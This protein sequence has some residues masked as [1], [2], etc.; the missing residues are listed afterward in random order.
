MKK[1]FFL[2]LVAGM[3]VIWSSCEHKPVVPEE[4]EPTDLTQ[5]DLKVLEQGN[6][7][8]FKLF[9]LMS[10]EAPD[11][12][13]CVSPYS[14]YTALAMAANGAGS[15]TLDEML[16]VLDFEG[17]DIPDLNESV[18]SINKILLA[19]D[20]QTVFET[21]NSVWYNTD[22]FSVYPD[23]VT[24]MNTYY[25]AS[26]EGLSFSDPATLPA[27]NGWVKEKTHE[28][29]DKI[30][31]VISP[32]DVCYLINALYFNGQ[33]TT[34]FDKEET[35][36]AL[37][38]NSDGEYNSVPTMYL[39]DTVWSIVNEDLQAVRLPYGDESWGMY[40][41]LPSLNTDLDVWC[42]E[43]LK[44]GWG[45]LQSQ[46]EPV[47]GMEVYLPQFKMESSFELSKQ[48]KQ[49]GMPTAFSGSADFSGLGPGPLAISQ[50]LHKT[51][52][53]VNEEGTEAAAVTAVVITRTSVPMNEIRF[54]RP[55]VF[56]IAEK[57]TGSIIFIGKLN[58][59][60]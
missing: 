52:I 53:D 37:F 60:Q 30:I 39:K 40:L 58:N 56:V 54:N 51:F 17:K 45:E 29:I 5:N 16:A 1:L 9:E 47:A 34:S 26:V 41:F 14:V 57:T 23:F 25:S 2:M 33:W 48:L 22:G 8:G 21:A 46:F 19:K 11:S 50:V 43:A 32:D 55:F 38:R 18:R 20:P 28:K 31:E 15:Q 42:S 24:S 27:I 44:E 10:N 49:M 6:Q 3:S 36:L 7:F 59:P 12:N 13:L 35:K 4:L